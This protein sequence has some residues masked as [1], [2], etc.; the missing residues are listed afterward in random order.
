[1]VLED[2]AR[3]GPL[4]VLAGLA[5]GWIAE[6]VSRAGGHGLIRDMGHGIAGSVLAGLTVRSVIHG[7]VGLV[8][9]FLIGCAGAAVV[10]AGRRRLWRSARLGA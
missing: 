5:V 4:L 2:I 3:M 6:V 10:I 8:A 1:M 7:D 9:M